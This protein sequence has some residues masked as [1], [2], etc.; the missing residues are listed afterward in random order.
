MKKVLVILALLFLGIFVVSYS[1]AGEVRVW[2]SGGFT[3]KGEFVEL[4]EN[5][6]IVRIRKT[7][8]KVVRVPL[9][10]LS[11]GD[12]AYV[13]EMQNPFVEEL[14]ESEDTES[15]V[16]DHQLSPKPNES[17]SYVLPSN[18]KAGDRIVLTVNG[19]DYAF[20]WCPPGEFIMGSD[21]GRNNEMPAHK[22]RITKGF[23]LLETEVT[24]A[25]WKSM[26]NVNLSW[27]KGDRN[28]VET[29]SWNDC[30]EFCQKL[31]QKLG[32]QVKLPTEAQWEYACRAG[33]T[34]DY[35]VNLDEMGWYRD[36]SDRKTHAVGLMKPNA[37][38]LYDMYGNVSEWCSDY[39]Y[40]K[41]Y[42]KSPMNDPE[43]ILPYAG[44]RVYRGGSWRHSAGGYW[45]VYRD[46]ED[47]SKFRSDN[48]GFRIYIVSDQD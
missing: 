25:M 24:Q 38:G 32:Q 5:G 10:K 31:S 29:V 33:T 42:D 11:E 45:S 22:V 21:N 23:W 8:G 2:T 14:S 44:G 47:D 4:T 43:N 46:K 6:T 16:D 20:R 18:P 39:Y 41:Y 34:G 17:K 40:E 1:W 30:Q 7:N 36:N 3:V 35:E 12:V 15:T 9:A 27:F 37:W 26:E 13:N 28:P 48:L 19:V